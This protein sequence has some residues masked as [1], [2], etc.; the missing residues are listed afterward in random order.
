MCKICGVKMYFINF[1]KWNSS[2]GNIFYCKRCY[3]KGWGWT[4]FIKVSL[5]YKY[6]KK[7]KCSDCLYFESDK[8]YEQIKNYPDTN[9]TKELVRKQTEICKESNKDSRCKFFVEK[10]IWC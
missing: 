9:I 8:F 6:R 5:R 4:P 10:C 1:S 3:R 2:V 7:I